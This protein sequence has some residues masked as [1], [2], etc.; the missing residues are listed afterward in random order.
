MRLKTLFIFITAV[1]T[2][3]LS[4]NSSAFA[5]KYEAEVKAAA[6]K[7]GLPPKIVFAIMMAE[8]SCDPLEV[9]KTGKARGLFQFE[10]E[11]W[12]RFSSLPFEK[13]FDPHENIRTAIKYLKAAKTVDPKGLAS[14]HNAGT[15]RWWKLAKKWS[16]NHPNK[17][18]RKIYRGKIT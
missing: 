12:K 17:T 9:D 3:F 18:Y 16:V 10:K 7:V 1:F 6:E 5:C 4:G 2:V 14:W 13:A 11:T 15:K 8:S